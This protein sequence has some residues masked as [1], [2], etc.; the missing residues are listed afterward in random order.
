MGIWMR[1]FRMIRESHLEKVTK[2]MMISKYW[3][4]IVKYLCHRLNKNGLKPKTMT[5]SQ[6]GTLRENKNQS[7]KSINRRE[8]N[9]HRDSNKMNP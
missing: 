4:S 5:M 3:L 9:P 7:L 1:M 2:G 8:N 6:A